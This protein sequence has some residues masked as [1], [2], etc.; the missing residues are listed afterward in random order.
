MTGTQ[1][2]WADAVV[3]Q[4]YVRSFQDSD[5]DGI[6]DLDGVASR[7]DYL[8]SLDIDAIWLTPFY[9]S[10]GFDHGYDVSDH[11]DID[12]TFGD[13]TAF[14]RVME[15]AHLAGLKVLVD[16]VPNHTS[17]LHPWFTAACAEGREGTAYRPYY[18]WRDP[19][20]DGGV[21]NNW[22]SNFGGPAW[23]LDTA[24]GQYYQH[25]YLPEQ[26]ELN[27]RHEPVR[28]EFLRILQFWLERGV[29]GF[30]IDVAHNL[31]K[32]QQFR[33][34][35]PIAQTA[36]GSERTARGRA[37][38]ARG[39]QRLHDIDQDDCPDLFRSWSEDLPDTTSGERPFLLGETVLPDASR[40]IRY[41]EPGTLDAAMWFGLEMAAFDADDIAARV[42]PALEA[43]ASLADGAGFL[44]W[45]VANH[46]RERLTSRLGS[47]H[48]ALAMASVV[49]PLPGPFMLY[50]GEELGMEN[51]ELGQGQVQDPIAVRTGEL[52]N[53]R[54][55]SRTPMP[56]DSSAG[57][58]FST[59]PPWIPHANLP[60][61]G[62]LG[63]QLT[64]PGS[65]LDRWQDLLRVWT[66]VRSTLPVDT[67]V[68]TDDGLL[69][70]R[71]GPL[72]VVL[73]TS[74]VPRFVRTD[75]AI[76]WSSSHADPASETAPGEARWYFYDE[77]RDR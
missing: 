32:D 12:P 14:E 8:A 46:D 17:H 66:R 28:E 38:S 18:I 73:N 60:A 6:G 1:R 64:A 53:G 41:I 20:P 15:K 45:F 67:Q 59:G 5:G 25:S 76:I 39:L 22:R 50:Q 44:G 16:I 31:L 35:P 62:S 49:L 36:P 75:A 56:W 72:R 77:S 47:R 4:I 57:R 65:T 61:D 19:A 70:I 23:T 69:D 74:A 71:R 13:L 2:W 26:P 3:Y 48:R 55:G 34:N 11:R 51:A 42:R 37:R 29:D 30:R 63:E 58:G 33:D 21:P 7:I 43:H 68:T 10:P 27:W 24:S 9:P 54:D 52:E 40:T